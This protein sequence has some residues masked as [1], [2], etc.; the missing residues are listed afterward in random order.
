[1][2]EGLMIRC[3]FRLLPLSGTGTLSATQNLHSWVTAPAEGGIDRWEKMKI[4][5]CQNQSGLPKCGIRHTQINPR[6]SLGT[7]G[8]SRKHPQSHNLHEANVG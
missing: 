6:L 7:Q 4:V 8:G 3:A 2:P 1:M 5:R